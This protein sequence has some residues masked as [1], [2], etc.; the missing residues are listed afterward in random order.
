M[1]NRREVP[2]RTRL[3]YS[4]YPGAPPRFLP[5]QPAAILL[6]SMHDYLLPHLDNHHH[7]RF[8]RSVRGV[9]SQ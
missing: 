1:T 6:V 2:D 5:C 3:A 4:D 9:V 7:D 8:K